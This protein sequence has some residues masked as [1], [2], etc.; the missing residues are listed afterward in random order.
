MVALLPFIL[1]FVI[2]YFLMIRPQSKKQKETQKMISS[3]H[4]G[5][6]VITIGGLYGTIVGIREN[7]GVLIIKIADNTKVEIS[8]TAVAKKL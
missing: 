8:K 6:K 5:D 3:L 7:D 1:I 2:I 4:K